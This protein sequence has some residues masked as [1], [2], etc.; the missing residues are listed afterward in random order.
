MVIMLR[1]LVVFCAFLSL[2]AF[3]K[4]DLTINGIK[5]NLKDN[6]EAYILSVS[7]PRGRNLGTYRESLL[8]ETQKGLMALGYYQSKIQLSVSLKDQTPGKLVVV[9]DIEPGDPVI[10]THIDKQLR[11]EARHDEEFLTF[12]KNLPLEKGKPLDHGLYAS[13]KSS[14]TSRALQRGY[15]NGKFIKSSV[16]V[17]RKTNQATIYLWFESGTRYRYGKVFFTQPTPAESLIRNM[18]T[19]DQGE[20][21]LSKEIAEFSVELSDTGYFRNVLVRPNLDKAVGNQVPIEITVG[22]KPT[23]SFE[24]GAGVTTDIGPRMSFNWKRPWVNDYGHSLG[25]N[26]ELSEPSQ[27]VSGFYKV[28]VDDPNTDYWNFQVGYQRLDENDTESNKYTISANRFSKTPGNWDRNAYLKYDIEEST[29]GNQDL[30]TQLLLPGV[31][32]TRTRVRGGLNA[33]W[34]DKQILGTEVS[35]KYWASDEDILKVYGQTKWLRSLTPKHR[36]LTR[37]ELGAIAVDSIESVPATMRFFAGGDQSIRG[38]SYKSIAPRDEQNKLIGG[39]YL[40][41]ASLEYS[42]PVRENWRIATFIDGGTAT[43][44]FSEDILYGTGIGAAWAS[45]IGPIKLFLGTPINGD[46]DG[47]RIHFLM[48]PEL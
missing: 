19:F 1:L 22:L 37:L 32:Y 23:N 17:E 9:V 27:T 10:I 13:V 3:A 8:E 15:F 26:V 36:I 34:G 47:V 16:E 24:I 7:E 44:D 46:E 39:K 2:S 40:A 4:V 42:Y 18:I 21:Y 12:L 29:Q 28:P 43:N 6:V 48:G 38:F 31:T 41:V 35:S 45:P 20:F 30:T 11:G 25:T 14:I 5:G 33:Y